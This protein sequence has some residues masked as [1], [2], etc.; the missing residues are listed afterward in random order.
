[1]CRERLIELLCECLTFPLLAAIETKRLE[2]L[3]V[4]FS[5]RKSIEGVLDREIALK[6]GCSPNEELPAGKGRIC[7]GWRSRSR[8][9]NCGRKSIFTSSYGESEGLNQIRI[10]E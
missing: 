2:W 10:G 1:M 8:G 5:L 7:R 6:P 3:I 9:G 4:P